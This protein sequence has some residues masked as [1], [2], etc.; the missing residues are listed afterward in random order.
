MAMSV[1]IFIVV[2][3]NPFTVHGSLQITD[4]K[5]P[6]MHY[7]KLISEKHFT[8]GRPLVILLATAKEDSTNNEVGYLIEE[9]HTSGRWPILVYDFSC[10][11]KLNMYTEIYQHGSYI[12]LVSG[13]CKEG[14]EYISRFKQETYELSVDDKTWL[15]W[16][17]RTKIVVSVI[18]NC[19]HLDNT[20]ISRAILSNLWNFG[21][22]NVI[23]LFLRSNEHSGNDLQQNTTDSAQG[24]YLELHTWYPYENSKRCNPAQGTVPVKVLTVRDFGEI[25]KRDIFKKYFGKNLHGCPLNV[26]VEI[27][28]PFVYPPKIIWEKESGYQDVYE[29]GMEIDL[30][31]M[32]GYSL[33]MSLDIEDSNRIAFRNTTA[34]LYV[35][36]Y[37]TYP[38]ALD[39]ITEQT[40]SYLN[41]RFVWY[42]PCAVKYQRWNRFFDIFSV[43]MWI[44]FALSLVLAVITVKCI[45]HYGQIAHFHESKSYSKAFTVT[46]II[47][48]VVLSVSVST[49]PRS[50]PLRLFFLGM[51][52]G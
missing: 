41:L 13:T 6:L 30:L 29:D 42:T 26:H 31:K 43:D 16:N 32:I 10:N 38:S 23:V 52:L 48:S 34:S 50:A 15:S 39:Y 33:N 49:Q 20:H 35:G 17:P 51:N 46:A 44:C 37:G 19:T 45:S 28:P 8:A 47:I 27:K 7:T 11:K 3:L 9:L 24:T 4:N 18:S 22:I 2:T 12:I 5:Y 1:L 36:G 14:E 21:V 25:R 40:R